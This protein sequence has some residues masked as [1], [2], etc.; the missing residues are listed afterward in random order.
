LIDVSLPIRPIVVCVALCL[1]AGCGGAATAPPAH[2]IDSQL[3]NLRWDVA[4]VDDDLLVARLAVGEQRRRVRQTLADLRM[5]RTAPAPMAGRVVG[6]VANDADHAEA[7]LRQVEKSVTRVNV[8][9]TYVARDLARLERELDAR[10]PHG[11]ARR[12]AAGLAFGRREIRRIRA[13]STACVVEATRLRD[14]I[15]RYAREAGRIRR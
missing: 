13:A 12:A 4:G 6:Y 8:G 2:R 7:G 5:V 9:L 14:Q 15:A 3:A 10:P 11:A 1:V